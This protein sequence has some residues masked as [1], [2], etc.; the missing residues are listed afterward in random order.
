MKTSQK[1][2]GSQSCGPVSCR[3]CG[4][5]MQAPGQTFTIAVSV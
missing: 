2:R 5:T 1:L 4:L 3:Y